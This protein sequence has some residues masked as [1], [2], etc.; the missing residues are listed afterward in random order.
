M[1]QLSQIL[2]CWTSN[3]GSCRALSLI[4]STLCIIFQD[5]EVSVGYRFVLSFYFY[6]TLHLVNFFIYTMSLHLQIVSCHKCLIHGLSSHLTLFIVSIKRILSLPWGRWSGIQ[7]IQ[8]RCYNILLSHYW[9]I[10]RI[11]VLHLQIIIN[12]NKG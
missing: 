2:F 5:A 7:R 1:I 4:I 10:R 12:M 11:I 3:V 9:P 6:L 8:L